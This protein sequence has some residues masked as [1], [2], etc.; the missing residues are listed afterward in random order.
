M[1]GLFLKNAGFSR[2]FHFAVLLLVLLYFAWT[3]AASAEP[4]RIEWKLLY[5]D[6]EKSHAQYFSW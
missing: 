6:L 4:A 3:R 2:R 5:G 1:L